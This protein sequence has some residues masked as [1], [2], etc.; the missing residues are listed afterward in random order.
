MRKYTGRQNS[1]RYTSGAAVKIT[2]AA[3][4]ALA[5]GL[6]VKYVI[7][8]VQN[9]LD[10]AKDEFNSEVGRKI[11]FP[12]KVGGGVALT[13]MKVTDG[14]EML[15]VFDLDRENTVKLANSPDTAGRNMKALYCT[16]D[17][18]LKPLAIFGKAVFR[19]TYEGKE[20]ASM[21]VTPDG[22]SMTLESLRKKAAGESAGASHEK[23]ES[24]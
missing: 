15:L 13:D 1:M 12:V 24:R 19:F 17:S 22:C 3:L 11:E 4:A 10:E 18:F 21:T 2:A 20:T 7:L 14:H 9:P 5:V 6:I 16:E 8:P 23:E